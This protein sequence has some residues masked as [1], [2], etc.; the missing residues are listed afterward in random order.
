MQSTAFRFYRQ[1]QEN[2]A[3]KYIRH[4]RVRVEFCEGA[5]CKN[6][7]ADDWASSTGACHPTS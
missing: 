4:P 6:A 3:T 5:P 7:Q 1:V 2:T